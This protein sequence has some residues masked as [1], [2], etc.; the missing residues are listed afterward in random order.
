MVSM[1]Q[2][3]PGVFEQGSKLFTKNLVPGTKV[4][5]ERLVEEKG[6]GFRQ[7]DFFRSKLGAAIKN[8]LRALP[9][10]PGSTVL[11]LGAAE[12]TTVSHVSDIVGEKGAVFGVDVSERVMRKFISLAE[13][14]KNIFPVVED[15]NKPWKYK[16]LLAER[17]IDVLF[18]DVS[19]K[20]QAQIFLKNAEYF[21]RKGSAGMLVVKA[22]SIS[23]RM[24]VS[25]V[26]GKEVGRLEEAFKVEQ[27]VNLKPFEKD[28]VLANC[29]KQ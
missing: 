7:W 3:F 14:R 16:G 2:V 23:Q 29:I 11:Y 5:G 24:D 8:G 22:K 13:Q 15:A 12:G 17:K 21:S 20:N 6:I 4:Y 28:H 10:K 25:D 1:K 27:I 19:Q 9:I 18:Q 26:F